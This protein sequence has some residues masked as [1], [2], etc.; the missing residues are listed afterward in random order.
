MPFG[1]S[2][3]LCGAR[4]C[5]AGTIFFRACTFFFDH[6]CTQLAIFSPGLFEFFFSTSSTTTDTN[7]ANP[8][9]TAEMAPKKSK[10]YGYLPFS[11]CFFSSFE[12]SC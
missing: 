5:C 11:S 9:T 1:S 10:K 4:D 7:T 8:P 6:S 2:E 12:Q 3:I